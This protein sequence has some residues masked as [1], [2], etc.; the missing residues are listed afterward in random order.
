MSLIDLGTVTSVWETSCRGEILNTNPVAVMGDPISSMSATWEIQIWLRYIIHFT[1]N[2]EHQDY[3]IPQ[4]RTQMQPLNWIHMP[5][6]AFPLVRV[7]LNFTFQLISLWI[8]CNAKATIARF[9]IKRKKEKK[10][11]LQW[12]HHGV[13]I[14]PVIY[15]K[16]LITFSCC[17]NGKNITESN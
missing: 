7:K 13:S 12:F 4:Q 2:L 16:I 14:C 3:S 5:T 9:S 10:Q 6:S 17:L 11:N 8:L 15:N 1:S